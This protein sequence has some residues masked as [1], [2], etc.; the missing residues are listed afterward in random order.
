MDRFQDIETFIKVVETGGFTN[1][2]SELGLS[3][4]VVSR[5]I[6]DLEN[7]L[8]A[9]LLNR[10]TRRL[11]PTEVGQAFYERCK[12]I[13]AD[14][15]EAEAAVT[16]LQTA[17]R[18][19]LRVS[20]PTS[21]GRIHLAPILGEF[22]R[23]YPDISLDV[24]LNDRFVDLVDEGFDLAIRV[25]HLRDSSLIATRLASARRIAI[26]SP[27]YL[28]EH[29]EPQTLS[30]LSAHEC[31]VYTATEGGDLW[32]LNGTDGPRTIRISG[33]VHTNDGE[34]M[35]RLAMAGHGIAV[36]PTF[37]CDELLRSGQLQVILSKVLEDEVGIYAVYPHS[38]H[39]SPKVRALVDFLKLSIGPRPAWEKVLDDCPE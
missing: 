3:K 5:R 20:A 32:R 21:L 15:Q 8:G 7:R 26:A 14:I 34:V 35:C 18:G 12:R 25:G 10:T 4:S 24:S 2:A 37:V 27:A 36:V 33:R 9:R 16:N 11:S 17:P 39:L 29:G 19:T 22:M 23:T 38:R 1:A 31:M 28:A 13:L 30:D 6:N